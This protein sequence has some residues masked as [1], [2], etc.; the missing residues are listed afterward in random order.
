M[1]QRGS[2]FVYIVIVIASIT[3]FI[4]TA[5]LFGFQ[6]RKVTTL[7]ELDAKATEAFNS[8]LAK[9][10]ADKARG[11]LSVPSTVSFELNG[12]KCTATVSDNST[13]I[14]GSALVSATVTVRDQTYRF[15]TRIAAPEPS[16]FAYA[17]ATDGALSTNSLVSAGS[18]GTDGS[19]YATGAVNLTNL[20][21]LVTGDALSAS[22]IGPVDLNILGLKRE[23][24]PSKL[25]P[26]LDG[27]VY[28]TAATVMRA[29]GNMNGCAFSTVTS[30]SPYPLLY[31]DGDLSLRGTLSGIG[32][33]YVRGN[34]SYGGNTGYSGGSRVVIIV[35]GNLTLGANDI[36]GTHYV[37]GTTTISGNSGKKI[38]PGNIVSRSLTISRDLTVVN[39][40]S[41][42]NDPN[43]ANRHR[44]P[45]YWP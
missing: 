31:V 41:I 13:E 44:L 33:I 8:L 37:S 24:V 10:D 17:I 39:D 21:N 25:F 40:L 6:A 29:G 11:Q 14:A 23:N 28:S 7:R 5:T 27:S 12:A 30:S 15:S 20:L 38:A 4:L 19:I 42:V 16:I 34:L 35:E 32:T 1:K 22:T 36:V 43:E 45:G 2:A 3:G 18:L 26:T 9:I